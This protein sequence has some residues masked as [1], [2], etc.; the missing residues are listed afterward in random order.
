MPCNMPM[1]HYVLLVRTSCSGYMENCTGQGRYHSQTCML[2]GLAK[3][4][5]ERSAGC[6]NTLESTSAAN[7]VKG[8]TQCKCQLPMDM[9]E[10]DLRHG[11]GKSAREH[12]LAGSDLVNVLA[13]QM[14]DAVI[15]GQLD[16][17]L[18]RDLDHIGAIAPEEGAQGSCIWQGVSLVL[19]RIYK[20]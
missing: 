2:N 4:T 14:L 8:C 1:G 10:N 11:A 19:S 15:A 17:C 5:K 12:A 9:R 16:G 20:V 18:W 7:K 13:H 3:L 6:S